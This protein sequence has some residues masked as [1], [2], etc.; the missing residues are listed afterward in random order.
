M[1]GSQKPYVLRDKPGKREA[2]QYDSLHV[3]LQNMQNHSVVIEIRTVVVPSVGG[4]G[5]WKG[6]TRETS[7]VMAVFRVSVGVVD[8][9]VNAFVETPQSVH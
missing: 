8:T 2:S 7:G 6:D 3:R 9:G 1:D 4:G 5:C